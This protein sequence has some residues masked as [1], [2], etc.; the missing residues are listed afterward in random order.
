MGIDDF[1]TNDQNI[2]IATDIMS[3]VIMITYSLMYIGI[4]S[5]VKRAFT[6]QAKQ[7]KYSLLD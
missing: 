1:L 7:R 2:E 4:S 6:A 5:S 3:T